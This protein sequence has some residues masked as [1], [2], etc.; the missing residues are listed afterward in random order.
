MKIDSLSGKNRK[1]VRMALLYGASF[2]FLAKKYPLRLIKTEY[3]MITGCTNPVQVMN[4][5][6][7][8][9]HKNSNRLEC[10]KKSLVVADGFA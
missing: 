7:K 6:Q 8:Y 3:K 10:H 9:V 4:K 2:R 1:S 5:L